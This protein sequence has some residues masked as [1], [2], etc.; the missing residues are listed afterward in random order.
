MYSLNHSRRILKR[1]YDWHQQK[2]TGLSAEDHERLGVLINA[3]NDAGESKKREESDRLAREIEAFSKIKQK[4]TLFSYLKEIV[5]ALVVALIIATVVRA[6]WFELYQI[7]T[8]SMRPNYRELDYLSVTKLPFGINIPLVTDHVLFDPAL[9]QRASAVTFTGDKIRTLDETT[10][11]LGVFPYKKRLIKR[12][13]GKPGDALYF[14][15]GKIYGIDKSGNP[16]DELLTSPWLEK[17]EY[18]PFMRFPG[19]MVQTAPNEMSFKQMDKVIGKAQMN[20]FGELTGMLWNG[21]EWTKDDLSALKKPHETIKTYSDWWGMRNY[22]MAR[23]LTKKQLK[24]V[25]PIEADSVPEG[26][27]YLELRHTPSLSYPTSLT[28]RNRGGEQLVNPLRTVIPL[29]QKDLD[30]LMDNMYTARLVF[31]KNRG[32]RYSGDQSK[33]RQTDPLFPQVPDG[34]YEFYY[35]KGQEVKY[36]YLPILGNLIV[37][38]PALAADHP[39]SS[40]APENIQRLFNLGIE[41]D[42]AFEPQG[43]SQP[44]YPSRYAY[45]RDGDLYVMGA[46][47]LKK[48]NPTL[49]AFIE[50]EE[51]KE[52]QSSTDKAYIAF[53]DYGPPLKEGKIDAD[54]VRTFGVRV[55]DRHYFVLGDNHAM[56]AD[57][58]IFGF[59]PEENLQGAPSVILWPAGHR[60]GTPWQQPYPFMNIPRAVVWL[61]AGLILMAWYLIDRRNLKRSYRVD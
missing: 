6:S 48:G 10:P 60:W 17:V 28:A 43:P 3:L 54:F 38:S 2:K 40:H 49:A 39:L 22:A 20:P 9:V 7:P 44:H 16:I 46:P 19:E 26:L 37:S 8:G 35:G 47:L 27:L 52:K 51:K 13:I 21:S 50:R 24:E 5:G 32:R 12:M 42:D 36:L 1:A 31:E 11:F 45:F 61:I 18:I 25:A 15:G 59:V 23:L 56:S 53:K 29:Q 58:R 30:T 4:K 41:M 55:P 14:Y 34:T 33:Y 57:S